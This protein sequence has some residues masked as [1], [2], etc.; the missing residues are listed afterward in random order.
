MRLK[1]IILDGICYSE[2]IIKWCSIDRYG[3]LVF[4]RLGFARLSHCI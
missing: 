4:P 1:E 2:L 3:Q